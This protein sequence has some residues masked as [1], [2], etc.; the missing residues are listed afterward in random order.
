MISTYG[1]D[2]RA[3]FHHTH[4]LMLNGDLTFCTRCARQCAQPRH[5]Q[6]LRR[7]CLPPRPGSV[8]VTRRNRLAANRD[9]ITNVPMEHRSQHLPRGTGT[10]D[11]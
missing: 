3:R 5:L 4:N 10:D 6:A 1:A 2:W 9:P 7:P 8:Y 11:D